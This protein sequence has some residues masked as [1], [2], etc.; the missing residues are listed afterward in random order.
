MPCSSEWSQRGLA[1][2]IDLGWAEYKQRSDEK[3]QRLSCSFRK[4]GLES[5]KEGRKLKPKK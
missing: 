5:N 2:L 1:D 4:G 3:W